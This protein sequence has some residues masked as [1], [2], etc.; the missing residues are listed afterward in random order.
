[1][2]S[3]GIDFTLYKTYEGGFVLIAE[4]WSRRKEGKNCRSFETFDSIEE[5]DEKVLY[6]DFYTVG[7][8][9]KLINRARRKMLA[10]EI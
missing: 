1:M 6:E 5:M 4:N 10:R 9:R 3:I 8:P 7:I 2:G